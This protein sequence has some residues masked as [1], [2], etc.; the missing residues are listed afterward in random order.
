MPGIKTHNQYA[1]QLGAAL[2]EDC[3]KAVLAAIAVSVLTQGGSYLEEAAN[4]LALEWERLHTAG[5]VP[6]PLPKKWKSHADYAREAEE[7]GRE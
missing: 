4:R 3:P 5:I 1:A 2:Y 6:Q 7:Q